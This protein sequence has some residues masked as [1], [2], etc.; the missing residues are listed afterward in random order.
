MLATEVNAGGMD[1]LRGVADELKLKLGSAVLVLGSV[2]GDKVN[3]VV[4]VTADL[5]QQGLHAGK[6]I[7]EIAAI[8]GGGGGG[9]PPSKLS[10]ALAVAER[11]VLAQLGK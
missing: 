1:A 11:L 2:E 6:L 4:A 3:L 7:K 5:V 10:E 9:K 8:C